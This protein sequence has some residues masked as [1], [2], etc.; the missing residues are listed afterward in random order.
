MTAATAAGAC[1]DCGTSLDGKMGVQVFRTVSPIELVPV[2]DG[3]GN[4]VL[5]CISCETGGPQGEQQPEPEP[6]PLGSLNTLAARTAVLAA[7]KARVDAEATAARAALEEALREARK[8]H[9]TRAVEVTIPDELA[10]GGAAVASTVTFN[11]DGKPTVVVAPGQMDAAIEW[12]A[13]R[14]P[15]QI[16]EVI[17]PA[18]LK[19]LLGGLRPADGAVVDA[20]GEIIPW[21]IAVPGAPGS[22]TVKFTGDDGRDDV[23]RAWMAGDMGDLGIR[24]MLGPGQG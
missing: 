10:P 6:D 17:R 12:V 23:L 7:V 15:E 8:K 1:T 4:R 2:Y 9:G 5:R 11:R 21:A 13:E 14:F 19:S 16:E 20:Q 18:Y 22:M 3:D 24:P